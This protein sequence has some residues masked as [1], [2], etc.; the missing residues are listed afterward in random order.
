MSENMKKGGLFDGASSEWDESK[1]PRDAEG[2]FTYKQGSA[3]SANTSEKAEDIYALLG[4]SFEGYKGQAAVDKL[5]QERQGHVKGA[6]HRADIGDIDLL[7]GND[8]VGLQH[9]LKRREE[10]GINGQEFVKDLAEVVENGMFR[11]KNE[12]G[13]FEFIYN[14]KIAIISPEL[15]GNKLTFLLTAYKTHS[16]K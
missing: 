9:I 11:K 6:F 10:Q 14:R 12:K 7:W 3:N 4:P 13:T 5:L 8:R 1:H 16:K 2:K 15:R